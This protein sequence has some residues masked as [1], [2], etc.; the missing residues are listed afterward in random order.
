M[1]KIINEFECAMCGQCCAC[2]DLVQLT[3]YE[4]YEL[5]SHLRM[6][7]VEFFNQYCELGVT[8]LTPTPH[9]YIRTSNGVCPFLKDNKCSVHESRP[10]ACRA[11]PARIYWSNVADMKA[12]VREKYPCIKS[13]CGLFKLKNGDILLGDFE[14]LSRQT[15]SYWVDDAYYHSGSG[16]FDLSIP[17]MIADHYIHDNEMREVVKRY[18]VNPE[19]PPSALGAERAYA[20]ISLALQAR[21]MDLVFSFVSISGQAIKEDD[22]IG[23]YILINT[24]EDSVNAL[25]CLIE[26]GKMDLSKVLV[27]NSKIYPDC[28]IISAMHGSSLEHIAIGFQLNIEK[29]LLEILTN[30]GK[31]PLNAFFMADNAQDGKMVGFKLNT[32][33]PNTEY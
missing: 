29:P 10:Y 17:Y 22:R 27:T 28:R 19:H 3:T 26:S 9:L 11:Y 12:F 24:D 21:M 32:G 18:V 6:K 23:K 20:R 15:I 14:L 16:E 4:L 1:K 5:A 7:P 2:Q 8:N 30:M 25:R 31:D 33:L 13:E